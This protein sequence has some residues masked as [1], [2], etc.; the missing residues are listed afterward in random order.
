MFK[1]VGKHK[2]ELARVP[3]LNIIVGDPFKLVPLN[4][5]V[6]AYLNW[7]VKIKLRGPG[8]PDQFYCWGPI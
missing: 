7:L 1:L 4:I 5:I 2:I 8:S 3:W 6:G